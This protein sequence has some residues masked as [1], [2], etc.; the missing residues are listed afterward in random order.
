MGNLRNISCE[1]QQQLTLR[2][3]TAESWDQ[4]RVSDDFQ[5]EQ[6]LGARFAGDVTIESG[7]RVINSYV[8]NYTIGENA[9]IEDVTRLECRTESTFANGVEVASVNEN[10]GRKILIYDELRA[11]TAYIWTIYRHYDLMCK[12]LTEMVK[13]YANERKSKIG[14]VGKNSKIIASKLIREVDIRES[15]TIE[16][17]SKIECA[18]LMPGS[19]VGVD[20]KLN[21][22]IV[23]ED[24]RVDTGATMERCFVGERAIVASMFTAVDSLFFASS[25]LENGEAASIFAGPYTVSHHKSSLLIAGLFSF[26]NAGSGSNQSNHLFKCGPVHQ[27]IHPRGCKFAS[28]AYIMAPARE[29]AFTM[30]KGYHAK[31]HDTEAFP[32]SYLIDDGGRSMLMPGANLVSYGTKRDI[33]KWQQR[34][35]R[36][37]KRD[38]INYEEHNPYMVGSMVRA[39]NALNSLSESQPDADEYMWERAVIRKSQLRRGLGFYNKAIAASLGAMLAKG[40]DYGDQIEGDWADVAGAYVPMSMINGIVYNIE[41]G[42]FSRLSQIDRAFIE[43]SI[44]YDD[45]AH[46]WAITLLT[47]LLG[48]EPTEEEIASMVAAS[49]ERIAELD[50]Q[51]EID[52]ERD[53]SLNMAVG[54][55]HDSHDPELRECDFRCVRGL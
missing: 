38:T 41:S 27:A 49:R 17:A 36:T 11:Q 19:F 40:R 7:A 45:L 8:A 9:L 6:L 37:K 47:Q 30:V 51:R 24:A 23:A 33:V 18:T 50:R 1:E 32:Y 46:S 31:H 16:G 2:G 53:N 44:R 35:K 10:G 14:R 54:Y 43:V 52:R 5:V 15:V 25:H 29:G 26:F 13:S 42:E 20:V 3:C 28:G 48:H 21:E 12:K 22:V 4:L 39:V 55:G 34:D